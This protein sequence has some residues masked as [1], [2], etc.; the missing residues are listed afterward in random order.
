[1]ATSDQDRAL[2]ALANRVGKNL[3]VTPASE[4]GGEKDELIASWGNDPRD[5]ALIL[6]DG[7]ID[8]GGGSWA[9]TD[10]LD[11]WAADWNRER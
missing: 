11:A 6:T 7:V 2:E 5:G 1:M 3:T 9:T 8:L 4:F 10:P